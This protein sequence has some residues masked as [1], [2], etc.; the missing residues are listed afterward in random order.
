MRLAAA[1]AP[2]GVS[3]LVGGGRLRIKYVLG[4]KYSAAR[5]AGQGTYVVGT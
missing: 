2:P 4:Y 1:R 3:S 5:L